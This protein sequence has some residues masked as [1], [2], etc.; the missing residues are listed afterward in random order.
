MLRRDLVF[1]TPEFEE[2]LRPV[3]EEVFKHFHL[4][5]TRLLCFLDDQDQPAMTEKIG[6]FYCGVFSTIRGNALPFPQYLINHFIDYDLVPSK[7]RYDQFIYVRST[8]CQTV[9][10]AV[11][12][13]AHE[14]THCRQRDAAFKVWLANSL[15]YWELYKLDPVA[16]VT[17]KPWD[18]PIEHEAQLNSRRIAIELLGEDVVNA[19]ATSKIQDNYDPDK[20][21]FFQGLAGAST[22]D[23]LAATKPWVDRYRT[24]MQ[25]LNQNID[26]D[27]KPEQ[28]IDFLK[29]DWW[30]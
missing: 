15:L 23:L 5:K 30:V 10:G 8:T 7:F 9:P 21:R 25:D 17:A 20:W 2:R 6:Q 3:C 24:G 18:I 28:H 1:K 29:P 13:L 4:P 16:I 22:Y 27:I 26:R 11:I 14:L 12:T 19:H